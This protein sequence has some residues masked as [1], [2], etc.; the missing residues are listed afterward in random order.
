MS[1]D[2]GSLSCVI[3]DYI[4]TSLIQLCLSTEE[5]TIVI[6]AKTLYVASARSERRVPIAK[7]RRFYS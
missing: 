4:L 5:R 7:P 3:D 1:K 2:K 6:V